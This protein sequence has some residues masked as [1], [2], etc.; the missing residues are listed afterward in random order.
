MN[1]IE[2][3]MTTAETIVVCAEPRVA[4]KLKAQMRQCSSLLQGNGD[5]NCYLTKKKKFLLV[6]M[7]FFVF[8]LL[9]FLLLLLVAS[10]RC[11]A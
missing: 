8:F 9:L 3:S 4:S 11:E 10:C 1:L 6:R 7:F 5:H 2:V